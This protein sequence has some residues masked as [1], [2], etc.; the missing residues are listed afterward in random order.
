MRLTSL[1]LFGATLTLTGCLATGGGPKAT[2]AVPTPAGSADAARIRSVAVLP[3]D[4]DYNRE[5]TTDIEGLLTGIRLGDTPYFNVVERKALDMVLKEIRLSQSGIVNKEQGLRL[6]KLLGI[7]AYYTGTVTSP[8]YH[9]N[10]YQESRSQCVEEDSKKGFLGIRK[11][12]RSVETKISCNKA[13]AVYSFTPKLIEIESGRILYS[14]SIKGVATA[15]SCSDQETPA[16]SESQLKRAAKEKALA[17]FRKDVAPSF[18]TIDIPLM[19][20]TDTISNDQAKRKLLQG[21]EFAKGNRLDRACELWQ[22]ANELGAPSPSILYNLGV[23]AETTGNFQRAGELY[24]KADRL[25]D[26]PDE[27]VSSAL[28]RMDRGRR[29]QTRFEEQVR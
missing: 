4:G 14:E 9:Q 20:S 22:E 21:L 13:E 28:A 6:G 7:K 15:N 16:P 11:C 17:A 23:C 1:T 27:R 3:F 24:R 19:D 29:Q 8:V 18:A 12:K 26:K 5:L 2:V 25:L 10:Y